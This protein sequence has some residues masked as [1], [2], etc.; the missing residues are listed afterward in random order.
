M[1]S[2]SSVWICA[3]VTLGTLVV[4]ELDV[5]VE[6]DVDVLLLVLLLVV[7]D[8]TD[9]V[10]LLVVGP[11]VVELLDVD[12]VEVAAPV[13]TLVVVELLGRLGPPPQRQLTSAA[14]QPKTMRTR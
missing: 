13:A 14:A 9:V 10:E 12:E 7:L 3:K 2:F 1:C 4:V 11:D 8:D 6:V 5:D